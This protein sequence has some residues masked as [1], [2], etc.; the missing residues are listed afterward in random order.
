MTFE[1]T[2]YENETGREVTSELVNMPT[3]KDA[4]LW[5]GRCAQLWD[6]EYATNCALC[7]SIKAVNI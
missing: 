7:W 6:A 5:A 2:F 4:T 1:I 3:E